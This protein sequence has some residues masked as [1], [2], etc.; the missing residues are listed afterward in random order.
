MSSIP[1]DNLSR[2]STPRQTGL[3]WFKGL[4]LIAFDI[5]ITEMVVLQISNP[6]CVCCILHARAACRPSMPFRSAPCKQSLRLQ[7]SMLLSQRWLCMTCTMRETLFFSPLLQV[8]AMSSRA[9]TIPAVFQRTAQTCGPALAAAL[10]S[11]T[12]FV[13]GKTDNFALQAKFL[14]ESA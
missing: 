5:L 3:Q 4:S 9:A 10:F 8:F 13:T 1:V 14:V 6:H 7:V 11:A 12:V 2:P